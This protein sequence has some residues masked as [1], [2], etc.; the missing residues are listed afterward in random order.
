MKE[1]IQEMEIAKMHFLTAGR[2]KRTA[3]YILNE[4]K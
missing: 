2:R 4:N 3:V 1:R